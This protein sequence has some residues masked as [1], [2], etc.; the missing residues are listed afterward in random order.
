MKYLTHKVVLVIQDLKTKDEQNIAVVSGDVHYFKGEED[1]AKFID[2][3]NQIAKE[4]N[5]DQKFQLQNDLMRYKHVTSFQMALDSSKEMKKV[6]ND[7]VM[8]AIQMKEEK[9]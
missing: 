2:L 3:Q 7:L 1:K 6:I 5:E 9:K 8:Q 4:T